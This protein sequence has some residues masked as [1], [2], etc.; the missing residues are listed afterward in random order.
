M[1]QH[2]STETIDR[3]RR[4]ALIGKEWL[5][6]HTHIA[7]CPK[8]SEQLGEVEKLRSVFDAIQFD[9]AAI[10]E[11]TVEHPDDEQLSDF[12]NKKLN[13]VD[14]EIVASHMAWCSICPV[15]IEEM[16]AFGQRPEAENRLGLKEKT[17]KNGWT[18]LAGWFPLA[19]QT[20]QRSSFARVAQAVA[21]LI[22]ITSTTYVFL[23][24]RS[25]DSSEKQST[26]LT[27]NSTPSPQSAPFVSPSPTP[28]PLLSTSPGKGVSHAPPNTLLG[29]VAQWR[30][31]LPAEYQLLST[32]IRNGAMETANDLRPSNG[33]VLMGGSRKHFFA[34]LSPVEQVIREN[35]PTLKWKP[36]E[37]AVEY[38]VKVVDSTL[39]I[40]LPNQVVKGTECKLD[41]PLEP[42]HIYVWQIVAQTTEG[43]GHYGHRLNSTR[44]Y[45]EFKVLAT[46]ELKLV[47]EA[48][49]NYHPHKDPIGYLALAVRYAK[50]GLVGDAER[51]LNAYL[52]ERP[53]SPQVIKM[54]ASLKRRSDSK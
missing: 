51:M 22:L 4:N 40:S 17:T 46:D 45:A 47:Q 48:E 23:N 42:G 27:Q 2:L 41:L 39:G 6:A 33:G 50:A 24:L 12:I 26:K 28:S 20:M 9:L 43:E 19:W 30:G 31:V 29:D 52:K 37:D 38:R 18:L 21:A 10:T 49:K 13:K 14:A 25:S 7:N 16:E 8:C 3:Y 44:T 53:A 5:A 54:L 35:Q 1:T 11:Q 36:L 15:E 32:A 34:L